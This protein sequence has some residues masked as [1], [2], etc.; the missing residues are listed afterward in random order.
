MST[1]TEATRKLVVEALEAALEPTKLEV[2]D[3][4]EAHAGHAGN[5]AQA[6]HYII[7][8]T[9]AAFEGLSLLAFEADQEAAGDGGSDRGVGCRELGHVA[10]VG[11][12][13]GV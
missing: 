6:G 9:S 7:R 10:S 1:S 11:S 5:E 4:S 12:D 8:I 3:H 2:I 13:Q